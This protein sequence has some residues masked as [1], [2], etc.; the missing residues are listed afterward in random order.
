MST[1]PFLRKK[2]NQNIPL[3]ESKRVAGTSLTCN[4]V[5]GESPAVVTS[6]EQ[7]YKRIIR[8]IHLVHQKLKHSEATV[9]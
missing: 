4:L 7:K 3:N 1:N 5:A 2:T 9:S 6:L 8:K